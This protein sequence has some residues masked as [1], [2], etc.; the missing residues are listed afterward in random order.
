MTMVS[1]II[2]I[3]NVQDYLAECL[4]SILSQTYVNF[5]I[6]CINDCSTDDSLAVLRKYAKKDIR[7]KIWNNDRNRGQ[8]YSRNVGL[9]NAVGDFILFVDAD[10][11]ICP[12]LLQKCMEIVGDSDMVCFDYKQVMGSETDVKQDRYQVEDGMYDGR[13]FLAEAVGRESII[14]APWSKLYRRRFLLDNQITFYNGIIYEDILFSFQCYVKARRIYS[15]K[16]K[17][18]TYRVREQS[19][20]RTG[21]TEK[22]IGSYIICICELM[23]WYLREDFDQKTSESIEEYIRKVSR[24]YISAYRR[25]GQRER[26]LKFLEDKPGYLKIYRTFS[27]LCVKSGKILGLNWKQLEEIRRY[28]YII[29][30]GAGDIARSAVEILDYYDIPLHGI[31]VTSMKGNRKS[32]L[33]NLV[34]ELDEYHDIK[35]QCLVIIG[36]TPKYYHEISEQLKGQGFTHWMGIADI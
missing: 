25:W 5:E 21:I 23:K 28:Q 14:I 10:D 33:G 30:Y 12:D 24:E 35:G 27:E 32:I 13:D 11:F 29:L 3:Y 34:R 16:Q 2:P 7:I 19:T 20:M 36:T 18:Y 9:S 31:A 1:V 26:E 4:E 6:L 8:A 22:S 17:L 15:L